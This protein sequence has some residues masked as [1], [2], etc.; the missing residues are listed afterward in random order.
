[1]TQF[2]REINIRFQVRWIIR[3]AA[4]CIIAS[5]LLL[6]V[7]RMVLSHEIGTN[8]SRSFYALK[9]M[10]LFLFPAVGFSV[11]FYIL[12][13]SLLVAGVT[14]F[15]SHS[16]AGPIFRLERLAEMLGRGD[17][18]FSTRLRRT[19]QLISVAET[20]GELRDSLAGPLREVGR[21]LERI[22][23]RWKELGQAPPEDYFGMVESFLENMEAE[24]EYI[25]QKLAP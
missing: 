1:M 12:V 20:V 22:D 5:L 3:L 9:N 10:E 4:A 8:F 25:N 21:S 14:I 19:D 23:S 18:S 2:Q 6:L 24:L 11:L 17:L 13:V 16:I 15:V 7:L